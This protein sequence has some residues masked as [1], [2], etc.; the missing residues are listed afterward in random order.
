MITVPTM[1]TLAGLALVVGLVAACASDS[2]KA[3][4]A[5][6]ATTTA[7]ATTEA[8]ATTPATVPPTTVAPTTTE[9]PATTEAPTT[10]E[11]P[12]TTTT[13]APTTTARP[14]SITLEEIGAL[15][16]APAIAW[17]TQPS[18]P[19][20]DAVASVASS[21]LDAGRSMPPDAKALLTILRTYP[22]GDGR[23]YVTLDAFRAVMPS[24]PFVLT[25]GSYLVG[26]QVPAGTYRTIH[27]V[28][29]CYWETL[30][31][32][33]EINDNNFVS[34]APQVLMTIRSSD[35]AVNSD[36]CGPWVRVG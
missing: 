31:Q 6:A 11:Q 10:T 9:E 4:P 29:G 35:Y 34:A 17:M 22:G 16:Q 27:S 20:F 15:L 7:P 25:D 24:I 18:G 26:A 28:D 14:A 33:A 12:T 21:L 23:V 1:R 3:E 30:D 13:E 5:S 36:G 32:A 8:A 2:N 19:G